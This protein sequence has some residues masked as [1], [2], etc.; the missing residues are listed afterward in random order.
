MPRLSHRRRRVFEA[1]ESRVLMSAVAADPGPSVDNGTLLVTGTANADTVAIELAPGGDFRVTFNGS[2]QTF[3]GV[4]AVRA[5]LLGGDD[6]L[7]L[8]FLN[9]I[10][11]NVDGGDGADSMTL[12]ASGVGAFG[13]VR[14]LPGEVL[15]DHRD[16]RHSG[17]ES[18]TVVTGDGDDAI[19]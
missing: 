12:V 3:P 17:V 5:D 15:D 9:G 4:Q 14:L 16:V 13:G 8:G 10:S 11:A 7:T 19:T 2:A 6:A 1:L 18:L